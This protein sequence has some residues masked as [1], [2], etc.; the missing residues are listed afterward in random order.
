MLLEKALPGMQELSP[1]R[2]INEQFP[3]SCVSQVGFVSPWDAWHG[4]KGTGG[5]FQ[6][7]F[8]VRWH[9]SVVL[10][11]LLMMGDTTSPRQC[12][13]KWDPSRCA[14]GSVTASFSQGPLKRGWCCLMGLREACGV[15]GKEMLF[16]Q[17]QR[18]VQFPYKHSI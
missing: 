16:K 12:A 8:M 6:C 7:R 13:G 17:C 10:P 9:F 5:T 3:F 1:A 4:S 11:S 18:R 2:R 14:A 15:S